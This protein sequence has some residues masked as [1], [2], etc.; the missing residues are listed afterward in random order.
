MKIKKFRVTMPL[1]MLLQLSACG[2]STVS[3]SA[4]YDDLLDVEIDNTA[5]T[6][7][8][9]DHSGIIRNKSTS[10]GVTV[11]NTIFAPDYRTY[12]SETGILPVDTDAVNLD[13]IS[14]SEG[15]TRNGEYARLNYRYNGSVNNIFIYLTDADETGI[16]LI[17]GPLGHGGSAFGPELSSI[18]FGS[19]IY[20]GDVFAKSRS[21]LGIEEG[22]FTLTAD[23]ASRTA[24]IEAQSSTT[25]LSGSNLSITS[26]GEISGTNLTM[27]VLGQTSLNAGLE[28][29]FHGQSASGV[30]GVYYNSS[31]NPTHIGVFAG[32]K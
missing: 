17:E 6:R 27:T 25:Q 20:Q 13:V 21:S 31:N 8:F 18:P 9:S 7:A 15:V 5:T 1:V 19:F 23:F 30:S 12:N 26:D 11:S 4:S 3:N 32:T 24:S 29:N 22:N 10:A 2:G 28:G 14:T 16:I